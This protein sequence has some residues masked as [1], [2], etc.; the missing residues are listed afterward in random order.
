MD[1]EIILHYWQGE[2]LK[3]LALNPELNFNKLVPVEL[4]SEHINYHL[5][6]LVSFGLVTK[7]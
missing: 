5:K 7:K 1:E 6:R 2:I 4:E 3:K